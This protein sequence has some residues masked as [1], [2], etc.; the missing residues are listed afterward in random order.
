G[1]SVPCASLPGAGTASVAV[2]A[3]VEGL[4]PNSTYH[5]R[6]VASNAGGSGPGAGQRLT[7]VSAALSV[8]T[9]TA[10]ALTQASATPP[11]TV[12]PNAAA[13]SH[14][15][16]QYAAPPTYGTS[17]PCAS[18]PGAGSAAVAVSARLQGLSANTTY[19][20]RIVASNAGGT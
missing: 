15:P 1:S 6:I 13:P 12:N 16:F 2:S 11:A 9:G 8:R 20:Y 19:H 18:L 17:V 3:G 7:A 14:C 4:A 10:S 5:F